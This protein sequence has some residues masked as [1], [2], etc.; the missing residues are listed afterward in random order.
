[1]APW[2][3]RGASS[4]DASPAQQPIKPSLSNAMAFKRYGFQ[5]IMGEARPPCKVRYCR[6][7]FNTSAAAD[8]RARWIWRI[9]TDEHIEIKDVDARH[10]AGHDVKWRA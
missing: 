1:M 7:F 5:T 6:P 3:L 4:A 8:S 2:L 10:K 9:I